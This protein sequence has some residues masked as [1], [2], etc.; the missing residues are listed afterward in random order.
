MAKS[1]KRVAVIE[2]YTGKEV[3]SYPYY[4]ELGDVDNIQLCASYWVLYGMGETQ[5]KEAPRKYGAW[6]L[7]SIN[8]YIKDTI[9]RVYP[10]E[11]QRTRT[12]RTITSAEGRKSDG[13]NPDYFDFMVKGGDNEPA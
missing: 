10:Y 11:I 5:G 4:S 8:W 1:K 7:T 6:S 3:H 2:A 13:T 9:L 12:G